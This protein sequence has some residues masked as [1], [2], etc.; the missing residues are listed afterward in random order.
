MSDARA[1]RN[2]FFPL[3]VFC[4]ALFIVTILA[5]LASV[6]GD[7][8]APLARLFD[9]YAGR[10]IAGEVAAILL[11]GF[12]ALLIDRRQA[13]RSQHGRN[14]QSTTAAEEAIGPSPPLRKGGQGGARGSR[15]KPQS[16]AEPS[17]CPD[18]KGRP[19]GAA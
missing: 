14:C 15:A 19:E 11:T 8:R 7:E 17:I 9:Q 2:P 13:L 3:A 10:L 6:F 1:P 5:M 18:G 4:S 16:Q 12:L